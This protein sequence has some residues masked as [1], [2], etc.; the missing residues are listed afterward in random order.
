M[1]IWWFEM[2]SFGV[3]FPHSER[4]QRKEH[5]TLLFHYL[6][7]FFRK[8]DNNESNWR[9]DFTDRLLEKD[10]LER[11]EPTIPL[12]PHRLTEGS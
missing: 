2:I 1:V 6:Q 8:R 4:C 9:K 11:L 12:L 5:T 7:A 10:S 3:G